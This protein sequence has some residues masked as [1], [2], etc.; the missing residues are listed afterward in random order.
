MIVGARLAKQL[1]VPLLFS[2]RGNGID[3][4]A[5]SDIIV[6]YLADQGLARSRIFIE[7]QGRDTVE[8]AVF[9]AAICK[10]K[11]FQRPILV[12]SGYHMKRA[13]QIFKDEKMIVL[14]FPSKLDTWS[15]KRY[16][17]KAYLPGNFQRSATALRE[18]LSLLYYRYVHSTR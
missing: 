9:S 13:E 2:G 7:N 6:R 16:T 15:G 10:N 12:T 5:T 18:Y 1:N 17:W 14:P 4:A 3:P 8:N 11:G